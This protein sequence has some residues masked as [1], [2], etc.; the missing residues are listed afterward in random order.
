MK[1]VME[2]S[3]ENWANGGSV[4]VDPK[5]QIIAGPLVD[6]EGILYADMDPEI[7]IQERQNFDISGHYSRF[8][9]FNRP[10]DL[11]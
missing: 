6:E 4:I 1:S 9:I 8:D 7:A 2:S 10:I 3:K 11:D 5:G